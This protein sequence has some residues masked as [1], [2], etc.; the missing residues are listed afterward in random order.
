MRAEAAG[1]T[2]ACY[3]QTTLCRAYRD[4]KVLCRAMGG[5]VVKTLVSPD[6][7]LMIDETSQGMGGEHHCSLLA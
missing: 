3:Q 1:D 7:A 4:A 2:E 6:A 5:Y